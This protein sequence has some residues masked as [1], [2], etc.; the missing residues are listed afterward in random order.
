MKKLWVIGIMIGL[1]GFLALAPAYA[2]EDTEKSFNEIKQDL[3]KNGLL[4][5][6][7]DEAKGPIVE[8]LEKGATKEEIEKPLLDLSS[9]G[10]G[11]IDFKASADSMN[12]LV[13][14]GKSP[15]EAGSVVSDAV[16][17]AKTEGLTGAALADKVNQAAKVMQAQKQEAQE[18]K[19][20]QKENQESVETTQETTKEETKKA[21]QNIEEG[22][23]KGKGK[24]EGSRK[25]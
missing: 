8:M 2:A 21:S 15:K 17:Q 24:A 7:I 19:K 16:A 22:G 6:E 20:E 10:V 18:L 5:E 13:K 25:P 4:A 14:S 23:D 12:D 1:V 11:G 3:Q 9:N